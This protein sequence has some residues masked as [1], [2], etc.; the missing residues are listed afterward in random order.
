MAGRH[1]FNTPKKRNCYFGYLWLFLVIFELKISCNML[2]IRLLS[3]ETTGVHQ[4]SHDGA[5]P[6]VIT[7]TMDGVHGVDFANFL[8]LIVV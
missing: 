1:P 4:N 7:H 6:L 3:H 5:I 2:I 8:Q